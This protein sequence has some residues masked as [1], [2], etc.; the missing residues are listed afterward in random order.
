[1]NARQ[2]AQVERWAEEDRLNGVAGQVALIA[3]GDP[4]LLCQRATR[5]WADLCDDCND[6]FSDLADVLDPDSTAELHELDV[7]AVLEAIRS[8]NMA[9]VD[10]QDLAD[11]LHLATLSVMEADLVKGELWRRA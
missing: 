7:D 5:L 10:T 9:G 11:I 1:M 6:A 8:G 2:A 4:C 3:D